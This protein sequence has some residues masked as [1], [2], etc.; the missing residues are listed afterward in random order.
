MAQLSGSR[1]FAGA[2]TSTLMVMAFM[3]TNLAS[4]SDA[5][6]VLSWFSP[7]TAYKA[8]RPL[9]PGEGVAAWA[10]R[11]LVAAAA[12]VWLAAALVFRRREL[13]QSGARGLPGLRRGLDASRLL[14]GPFTRDAWALKGS[15]IAWAFALSGFLSLFVAIEDTLRGPLEEFLK[16]VGFLGELF[17]K[18]LLGDQL[19]GVLMFGAFVGPILS[20][21]A[22]LQVSRWAT[23]LGEGL[24]VP[25]LSTAVSRARLMLS[26]VGAGLTVLIGALAVTWGI[27]AL[28]ALMRGV[29]V[30]GVALGRGMAAAIT[31]VLVFLGLGLAV[32]SWWRAS[33]AAPVAGALLAVSFVFDVVSQAVELPAWSTSLSVFARLGNPVLQP[34]T[35]GRH[36]VLLLVGLVLVGLAVAG[37]SRKDLAE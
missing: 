28:V 14:R 29:D 11:A 9:V 13:N 16:N 8:S 33:W 25:A 5:F 30:P 2:L 22:I 10:L 17:G 18:N 27:V 20:V 7:F 34:L 3:V 26:R 12:L 15:G 35:W 19:I 37:F 24:F 32:G 21:F 31:V 23:E 6:E 36:G 4:S 1:G